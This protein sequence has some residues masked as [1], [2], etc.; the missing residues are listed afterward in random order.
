MT[1]KNQKWGQSQKYASSK[2]KKNNNIFSQ[3][4]ICLAL[5]YQKKKCSLIKMCFFRLIDYKNQKKI[6]WVASEYGVIEF[7]STRS[8]PNLTVINCPV[9]GLSIT[10]VQDIFPSC[11]CCGT[12]FNKF[13][14]ILIFNL[15]FVYYKKL[16]FSLLNNI[17]YFL[18]HNNSFKIY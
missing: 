9:G 16:K 18:H 1:T 3:L 4:G 5:N 15:F 7:L 17:K 10:S 6:T 12:I 14:N 13:F 8:D 11:K 2:N